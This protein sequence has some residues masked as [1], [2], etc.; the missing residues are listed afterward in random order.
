MTASGSAIREL[1]RFRRALKAAVGREDWAEVAALAEAKLAE[2]PD[3]AEAYYVLALAAVYRDDLAAAL[4]AATRACELAPDT[5]D[6]HDLL[7]VVYGLAGDV[8]NALFHGKAAA[9]CT[10]RSALAR[11][12]PQTFPTLAQVFIQ[13]RE[14]PL[15]SRGLAAMER[16]RWIEA[17]LWLRQ[18]LAFA[19]DC[20]EAGIGLGAS[21][22]AQDQPLA[23]VE[24]LRGLR[25]RLAENAPL[26]SL[27]GR[28]LGRIG[29]FDQANACHR[30]A[31]NL[32][33]EDGEIAAVAL[34]D[35]ASDP[36]A[37]M[38]AL[39]AGLLAWGKTF[40]VDDGRTLPAPAGTD[41]RPLTLGYLV[42]NAAGRADAPWLADI[43]SR[44][45]SDRF[46]AVGFG[47]GP[48][49]T[50]ANLVFQKCVDRWQDVSGADAFTFAAMVRAE[51]VHILV[52]LAGLDAPTLHAAFASRM[53]PCQIAWLG[54]PSL[55]LAGFDAVLTDR[56]VAPVPAVR[57]KILRLG[58]V[59]VP[60]PTPVARPP[61]E[62]GSEVL[63]MADAGLGEL[64]AV[65]VERWAAILHAAPEAR[66]V[67]RDRGFTQG[68]ALKRVLDIFG[69]F[70]VAHRVDVI[71][72]A[73]P[74]AFFAHGDV[75]LLPYPCPRPASLGEALSAGLPVVCPAGDAPWSRAAA[76]VLDHLGIAADTVAADGEAYV[77][78][79]LRWAGSPA[80]RMAFPARLEEAARTSRIWD[81][82]A[83]A[84]DLAAALEAAWDEVATSNEPLALAAGA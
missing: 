44:R 41:R 63:F 16:G 75:A 9:G 23:A 73:S 48:L 20:A 53:A 18:H 31:R 68:D 65:T 14:Q 78:L 62:Q 21:L 2:R 82:A 32:A 81:P 24:A 52:D 15:L 50:P 26:A 13:I 11:C 79:A 47:Y 83:R 76:S 19:P 37:D 12:V 84:E 80:E 4:Q 1:A 71:A 6:H 25:H 5:A 57:P 58:S 38:A 54:T 66:L 28:A 33:P 17:E 35:A 8:N 27:L 10:R 77:V 56:Y 60:P 74:A 36:R 29:E 43:L 45:R 49:S 67:L 42:A 40:G 34:L 61:R 70:G 72:E 3:S 59:P 30:I 55:G 22:L 69:T 39:G 64:N 51:G 46:A 7:A